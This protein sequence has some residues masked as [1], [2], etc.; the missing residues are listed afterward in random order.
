[1][2]KYFLISFIVLFT[3]S[4]KSQV[5]Q[6]W[7]TNSLEGPLSGGLIYKMNIDGTGFSPVFE[8]DSDAPCMG[9][10]GNVVEAPNGRY[11]GTT[12]GGGISNNGTLFEYN[13]S[14]DILIKLVQFADN[15]SGAFPHADLL[16]AANGKLYGTTANGGTANMGVLFEYDYI[17][18]EYLK[19]VDFNGVSNGSYP[20]GNLFQATDGFIYGLTPSGGLNNHGVIFRLDPSTHT[21]VKLFDLNGPTSGRSPQSGFCQA[22]NG[23]LFTTT[24]YGGLTDGGTILEYNPITGQLTKEFNMTGNSTGWRPDGGLIE[25]NDGMLYGLTDGYYGGA[26]IRYNY[27]DSIHTNIMSLDITTHGSEALGSFLK[28]GDGLLYA[29]CDAGGISGDGTIISFNTSGNILTKL[30]DFGPTGGDI[31]PARNLVMNSNGNIIGNTHY[32]SSGVLFM[33]NPLAAS[34]TTIFEFGDY[35]NGHGPSGELILHDDAFYGVTTAGGI[36]S[37]GCIYRYTPSIDLYEQLMDFDGAGSGEFPIFGLVDGGNGKFYSTTFEGGTNDL[38]VLY[39]YDPLTLTYTKLVDFDGLTTGTMPNGELMLADNGLLYGGTSSGGTYNG[40]TLFKF[41]P[42]TYILTIL[43]HFQTSTSGSMPEGKLVQATNGKLYGVTQNGGTILDGTIFEFDPM[44]EIFT[45]K[46]SLSGSIHGSKPQA[47]LIEASD[48]MLYGTTR[49]EGLSNY[50]ALFQYNF[51]TNTVVVKANFDP[52]TDGYLTTMSLTESSNGKLYAQTTSA[53]PNNGGVI[54]EYDPIA[55]LFAVKVIMDDPITGKTSKSKLVEA[56]F[57]YPEYNLF[58]TVS[59]CSGLDYTAPDGTLYSNVTTDFVHTSFLQTIN[60][61]DSIITSTITAITNDTSVVQNLTT[62]SANVTTG[63]FQWIDCTNGM[64]EIPGETLSTYTASTIGSYAV[65]F[66]NSGC[67]DTSFCFVISPQDFYDI[68][69]YTDL[70]GEVFALPVTTISLCDGFAFAFASGGVAPYQY[71]WYT[72]PN[73]EDTDLLDS[74]CEGF[75]TLKIFDNIGDSLMVDYYVTDSANFYYWYDTTFINYVDTIYIAAPNCILDYSLPLDSL[76]ISD[77]YYLMPDTLPPG[78]LYF[79]ELTY[80]QAGNTYIHQDTIA[81]D[82]DG[83]YLIDFSVYCPIK[84]FNT[85]KTVLH[86]MNYPTFLTITD[87]QSTKGINIYPNPFTSVFMLNGTKP[88]DAIDVYTLDGKLVHSTSVNSYDTVVLELGY[89]ANG[90]YL[91]R[92][93]NSVFKIQK[94]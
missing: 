7:G 12:Q 36:N 69:G 14:T 74:L 85:I 89:L 84:S 58:E 55:E 25:A 40:G 78:D 11:Y 35:S 57:C 28:H 63:L 66:N 73:N 20:I 37:V 59:V 26:I 23:N 13:P 19:L 71:D 90:V 64:T 61:C 41:D 70:Y 53:G 32:G 43:H 91:V 72:Q 80:Y 51:N 29:T 76:F 34:Y 31:Q 27:V 68:P 10:T 38:G 18:K 1:M 83:W 47:G 86:S 30:H 42:N 8:F 82:D 49:F 44:T 17:S 39:E 93:G 24:K 81:L 9:P 67:E 65:I 5:P 79:I 77:S 21:F 2:K 94:N 60:S 15:D 56:T 54:Y 16:L 87:N 52:V 46:F 3:T 75:H 62:L 6:L 4:I 50:G 48:G 45:T 88:G 22:S 33:Y 92:V